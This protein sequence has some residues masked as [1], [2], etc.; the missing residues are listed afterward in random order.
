MAWVVYDKFKQQALGISAQTTINL[1]TDT[2]KC[3]LVTASYTPTLAS[4]ASLNTSGVYSNQVPTGTAYVDRGPA[5][6]SPTVSAPASDIITFSGSNIVIAQDAGGGFTTARYAI[7]YKDTGTNS[8]SFLICYADL[9][10]NKSNT[11]GSLTLQIDAAGI[12]TLT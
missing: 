4:D 12:F 2:I 10:G 6:P 5:L 7:L 8:T 9:G 3:L 1:A 11:G